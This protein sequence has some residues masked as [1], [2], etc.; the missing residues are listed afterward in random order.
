VAGILLAPATPLL[1]AG[2]VVYH[3]PADDGLGGPPLVLDPGIH[4]IFLYLSVGLAQTAAGTACFDGDGDEICGFDVALLAENGSVIQS[5]TPT[6]NV[7]SAQPSPTEL[8][9]NGLNL[10]PTGAVSP[11]RIGTVVVDV[12][13]AVVGQVSVVSPSAIVD[14]GL[15]RVLIP[16]IPVPEP[17]SVCGLLAGAGLLA[18]LDRRRRRFSSRRRASR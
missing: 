17:G 4:S 13:P 8:R 15:T 9:L 10:Q 7:V 18:I 12:P 6:G 11:I 3:S 16:P 1:A 2:P 5:F 14:A